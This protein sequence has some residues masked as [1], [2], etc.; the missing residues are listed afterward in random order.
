MKKFYGALAALAFAASAPGVANAASIGNFDPLTGGSGTYTYQ[1]CGN[2]KPVCAATTTYNIA[3]SFEFV[4][5][6]NLGVLNVG[7]SSSVSGEN[8]GSFRDFRYSIQQPSGTEIAFGAFGNNS[9][10]PADLGIAPGT[11]FVFIT[12][13]FDSVST[14]SARY[15]IDITTAPRP[16]P[17]PGTLALL[18]LGLIG[19]GAARRR[20]A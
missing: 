13:F 7:A 10:I 18:G 1:V 9:S 15:S 17:E 4:V 2:T 12:G 8:T 11:Y 19:L 5:V 3:S 16:T 6:N 20:K 14:T